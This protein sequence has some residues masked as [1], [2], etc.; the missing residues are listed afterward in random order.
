MRSSSSSMASLEQG[1]QMVSI[2]KQNRPHEHRR[3]SVSLGKGLMSF[4]TWANLITS[5]ITA[6]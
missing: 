4:N 3:V 2:G 5:H 6:S 1:Q